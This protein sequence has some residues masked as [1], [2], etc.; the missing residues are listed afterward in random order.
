MSFVA[1]NY[2]SGNGA[3]S[4]ARVSWYSVFKTRVCVIPEGKDESAEWTH[5]QSLY[6]GLRSTWQLSYPEGP[7]P[8]SKKILQCVVLK[9]SF[10]LRRVVGIKAVTLLPSHPFNQSLLSCSSPALFPAHFS[11]RNLALNEHLYFFRDGWRWAACEQWHGFCCF[12]NNKEL[13]FM[14]PPLSAWLRAESLRRSTSGPAIVTIFIDEK[15]EAQRRSVLIWLI[16]FMDCIHTQLSLPSK[17]CLPD[18]LASR[19]C[20]PFVI[21]LFPSKRTIGE[22]MQS[23]EFLKANSGSGSWGTLVGEYISEAQWA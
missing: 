8:Q 13:I 17:P 2:T 23:L 10:L 3:S 1:D 22:S 20:L 11:C 7:G 12:L 19:W 15:T 5:I 4:W 16:T 18:F 14:E 9:T 21:W 6:G